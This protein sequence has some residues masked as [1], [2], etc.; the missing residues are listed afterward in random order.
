MDKSAY[1]ILRFS[2]ESD[3]KNAFHDGADPD[4]L[5]NSVMRLFLSALS[6]QEVARQRCNRQFLTFR[7]NPDVKPPSWAFR[8]PGIDSR[9][10]TL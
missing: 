1:Q 6:Q 8:K 3:I 7:R 10:P 5:L 2:V 4:V 9:L